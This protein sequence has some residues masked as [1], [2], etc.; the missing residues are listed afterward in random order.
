MSNTL[1]TYALWVSGELNKMGWYTY[2]LDISF[3]AV[4]HDLLILITDKKERQQ[5]EAFIE[6][7]VPIN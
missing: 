4:Y 3:S 2:N 6:F 7:L 1:F 5:N